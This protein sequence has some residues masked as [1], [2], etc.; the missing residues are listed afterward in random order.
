M[1]EQRLWARVQMRWGGSR[2]LL[3]EQRLRARVHVGGLREPGHTSTHLAPCCVVPPVLL[4]TFH[5]RRA[6]RWRAPNLNVTS[7]SPTSH[8]VVTLALQRLFSRSCRST[9]A[10]ACALLASAQLQPHLDLTSHL[11]SLFA[12]HCTVFFRSCRSTGAM[13]CARWPT[14]TRSR[15]T[16]VAARQQ[17]R[18][19]PWGLGQGQVSS[20]SWESADQQRRHRPWL[21]A[22]SLVANLQVGRGSL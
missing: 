9:G 11:V 6:H 17:T 3:L 2:Q 20:R 4:S 15:P 12:T 22:P 18:M 1:L 21:Q 13:A 10:M 8:R 5:K 16:G 14:P 7:C 19:Q